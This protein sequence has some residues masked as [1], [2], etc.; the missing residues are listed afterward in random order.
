MKA[1]KVFLTSSIFFRNGRS[2]T[3]PNLPLDLRSEKQVINFEPAI[4]FIV[5]TKHS[6]IKKVLSKAYPRW[7]EVR[8]ALSVYPIPSYDAVS[9]SKAGSSISRWVTS[10][11]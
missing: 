7:S 2:R 11:R 8:L 9:L 4:S 5:P 10:I 6:F 3:L 1:W